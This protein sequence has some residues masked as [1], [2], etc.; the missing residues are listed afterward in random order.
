[1][2]TNTRYLFSILCGI[3][4][5]WTIKHFYFYLVNRKE[6]DLVLLDY[7]KVGIVSSVF[8]NYLI[9]GK[10]QYLGRLLALGI[11]YS[12]FYN[13]LISYYKNRK[14]YRAEKLGIKL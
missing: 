13:R 2:K 6:L 9:F 14:V 11:G 7:I 4:G 1:M 12:I 10:T 5:I 3:I 8:L